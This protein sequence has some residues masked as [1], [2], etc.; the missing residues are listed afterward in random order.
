MIEV[1]RSQSDKTD[2]HAVQNTLSANHYGVYHS[3]SPSR[4]DLSGFARI[5]GLTQAEFQP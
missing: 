3:F 1:Y 4:Q 5:S 2:K